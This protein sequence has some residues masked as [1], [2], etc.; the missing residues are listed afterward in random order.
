MKPMTDLCWLCQ[1]N[2]NAIIRSA[3][4]SEEEKSMVCHTAGFI[5][6]SHCRNSTNT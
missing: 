5:H 1:K 2:S 6:M 4:K 3:N